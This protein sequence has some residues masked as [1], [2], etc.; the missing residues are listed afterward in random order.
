VRKV[1][2]YAP[3]CTHGIIALLIGLLLISPI[4]YGLSM[5]LMRDGDIMSYP[6]KI[7]PVNITFDNY[8]R[9]MKAVPIFKYIWNS[10]AVSLMICL[11]QLIT[12]SMAA[13][14]FSFFGFPGKKTLFMAVLATM[15]IPGEATLISNFLNLTQW[16]FADTYTGLVIPF[17]AS[18]MGIFLIR[19][20]YLSVPKEI[21]EAADI[22]GC[23]DFHFFVKILTPISTPVLSALAV[24]AI[25]NSWN[26]YMWPL[27]MTNSDAKRTVQIGVAMLK[28]SEGVSYGLVNAGCMLIL[29]P[30]ILF[31]IICQKKMIGAMMVGSL[32]G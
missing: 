11:G 21:K 6:P 23:G 31:F 17:T 9:V 12:C 4:L 26:Q 28:S 29:L 19:Q 2:K 18:G 16:G 10:S 1:K 3:A 8:I 22:D 14:A 20:F 32:K 27:L 24:Y 15:L 13:Y 7:F 5:S 25:I 30:S